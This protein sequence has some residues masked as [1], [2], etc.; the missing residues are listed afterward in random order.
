MGKCGGG[1]KKTASKSGRILW[2]AWVR[3]GVG[4][5]PEFGHDPA[6][7]DADDAAE[8]Y[9]GDAASAELHSGELGMPFQ[10]GS[11]D[12][13]GGDRRLA[14]HNLHAHDVSGDERR[15]REG[16]WQLPFVRSTNNDHNHA[17]SAAEQRID[18]AAVKRFYGRL[19]HRIARGNHG[20]DGPDG[21]EAS[22]F[23]DDDPK[24]SS[25]DKDVCREMEARP[26]APKKAIQTG[27]H[28]REQ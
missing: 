19:H 12:N 2:R 10:T 26:V 22:E 24:Y 15:G 28:L 9:F 14:E 25:R 1:V 13:G 8:Q 20:A 18:H 21:I 23:A 11:D 3:L 5:G 6:Y 17:N 27:V 16:D 7:G 4:D